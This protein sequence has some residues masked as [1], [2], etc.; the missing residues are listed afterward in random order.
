MR[1]LLLLI[2]SAALA[3]TPARVLQSL[4]GTTVPE[5]PNL[6]TYVTNRAAAIALGKALYWDVQVSSDGRVSCATCHFHAGADA[7]LR[8][9]MHPGPDNSYQAT[10]TGALSGPNQKPGTGDFP[11]HVLDDVNNRNS[12]VVF[13]TNDVFASQGVVLR[14]FTGATAGAPEDTCAVLPNET[15]RRPTPRHAPSVINAGFHHRQ[16]ADGRAANA[17]TLTLYRGAP[18]TTAS[19]TFTNAS[20]AAQALV[21][22]LSETEMSCRGRTWPHVGRRLLTAPALRRQTVDATDSVLGTYANA[23]KGLRV[24]YLTL[25]QQ[26]FTSNLWNSSAT[27]NGFTQA[28]LNFPLFFALAVQ[29]YEATLVSNDAPLDRYL[30]AYPATSVANASAL[31]TREIAGLNVFIGKGRC[32][33]CHSGPQLSNAGTPSYVSPVLVESMTQGDGNAGFYDFGFY[34]IGA[35]PTAEDVGLGGTDATG[36]PLSLARRQ[37][38]GGSRITVDGA[39]KTPS[40]RNVSLTG[41]YFHHGGVATLEGVVDFYNRGGD[42]RGTVDNDTSGFGANASN[43]G[44]DVASLGLAPFEKEALLAFLRTALTDERV[45]F[46]RAPFDHPE[47]P[48]PDGHNADGSTAFVIMPATGRNGAATPVD[49]FET[50]LAAGALPYPAAPPEWPYARP[51]VTLAAPDSSATPIVLNATVADAD[52]DVVRVEFYAG[53]VKLGED[54]AAPYTFNWSNAAA[55]THSLTARAI[56]AQGLTQTSA[57]VSVTIGSTGGGGNGLLGEY[58]EGTAFATRRFQRTDALVN[59]QWGTTGP[60]QGLSPRAFSVRWTGQLEAPVTG[61]VVICSTAD[62]GMRI[63]LQGAVVTDNYYDGTG[64]TT[65]CGSVNLT[66]GQKYPLRA[67]YFNT[68]TGRAWIRW[69]YAGGAYETIPTRYLTAAGAPPPVTAGTGLAAQ[70]FDGID[71][72]ALKLTR[73]DAKIDFAW[74]TAGPGSGVNASRYSVRWTGQ[75]EAPITGDIVVCGTSDDG[76]RVKV[77]GAEVVSSFYDHALLTSCGNVRVEQGQRYPMQVDYYNN[78]ATGTARLQWWYPGLG[79]LDVVPTRFL[80]ER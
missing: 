16:F 5:P 25:V 53:A 75:L 6:G 79:G 3:Q 48:I 72:Q 34:N 59:F 56:D 71:F 35:R 50:I 19:V 55:G 70:Y 45:R 54:L 58:F 23:T 78:G 62:S 38:S 77:N 41:P 63:W 24:N 32:V 8:N 73:V 61:S 60:G 12:G 64:V 40:L 46:E 66:Q 31:T 36:A 42:R 51:S 69:W 74:N 52:N 68:G 14:Q 13:D 30:A 28:E 43:L 27:A 57:P 67:D 22:V 18:L 1:G 15:T 39:F 20:L 33:S 17:L 37:I 26:A 4:K 7:R 21:P 65:T 47:L 11:F 49:P 29:L 80:F 76:M 10:R 44:P 9:Q 2:A